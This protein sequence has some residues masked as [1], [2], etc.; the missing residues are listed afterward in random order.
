MHDAYVARHF[1]LLVV[2]SFS[3]ENLFI[4]CLS[5]HVMYL[6]DFSFRPY[7]PVLD[8]SMLYIT[9]I[10]TYVRTEVIISWCS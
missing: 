8:A 9:S 3:S 5:C 7:S 10:H 6:R 1:F 2:L 4:Y